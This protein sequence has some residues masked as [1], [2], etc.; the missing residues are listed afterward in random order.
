[1]SEDIV[2][3]QVQCMIFCRTVKAFMFLQDLQ[4]CLLF[5]EVQSFNPRLSTLIGLI[6]DLFV[7]WNLSVIGEGC[8]LFLQNRDEIT[9][10]F[11]C[12]VDELNH[13]FF[14]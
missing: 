5:N 7:Q 13:L 6:D 3:G 1:M 14:H 4:L 10:F 8:D 12:N 2:F 9:G 11:S